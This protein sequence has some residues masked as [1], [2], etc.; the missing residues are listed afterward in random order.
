M[1]WRTNLAVGTGP[2]WGFSTLVVATRPTH[3]YTDSRAGKT[4]PDPLSTS[5]LSLKQVRVSDPHCRPLP[6]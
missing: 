6:S 4:P 1:S 2:T 5:H 3:S